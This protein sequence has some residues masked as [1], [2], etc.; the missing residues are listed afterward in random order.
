MCQRLP[1]CGIGRYDRGMNLQ[2]FFPY[3]IAALAEAVSRSVAQVYQERF[4]LS[5]D[6]WRVVA[7]L[8]DSGTAKTG[9]VIE[10]TSLDKMQVSRAVQRLEAAGLL[11]REPDAADAR[12]WVL[13][14]T[15]A[16]RALYRKI[17]P[18]VA[19]REA[20]LLET[21]DAGERR[22]LDAAM[23]KVQERARI[24]GAQG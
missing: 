2:A 13:H 1:P 10:H 19:A 22:A 24:L 4:G 6:E 5:R 11:A 12:G 15:A 17:V 23:S 16:G 3:R 18:L 20:F 14:L 7:A 9:R 21:L 8:A